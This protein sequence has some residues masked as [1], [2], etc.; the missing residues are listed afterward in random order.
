MRIF[1]THC[2]I[3]DPAFDEDRPEVLRR[4]R[5]SGVCRA[6]VVASPRAMGPVKAVRG[7]EVASR[8][9]AVP[10]NKGSNACQ[11]AASSPSQRLMSRWDRASTATA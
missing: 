11:A 10:L 9:A 2:H 6:N 3:A 5:E 4:M 1:D 7:D 8:L